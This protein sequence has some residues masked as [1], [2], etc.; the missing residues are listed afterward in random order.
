MAETVSELTIKTSHYLL[1]AASLVTAISFNEAMKDTVHT[2]FPMPRNKTIVMWIYA[3]LMV[4]IL[5]LLIYYLP[6]TTKELPK[7][8]QKELDKIHNGVKPN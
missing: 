6:Q 5:V 4:L 2:I 1:T 7:K 8:I 3:I